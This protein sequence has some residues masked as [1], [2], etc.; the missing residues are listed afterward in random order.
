MNRRNSKKQEQVAMFL[1]GIDEKKQIVRNVS[2]IQKL[3]KFVNDPTKLIL[4]TI[5]P[6]LQSKQ[7]MREKIDFHFSNNVIMEDYKEHEQSSVCHS[8]KQ[9]SN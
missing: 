7:K 8:I 4:S 5:E 9:R 2:R 6:T 3:F 1:P